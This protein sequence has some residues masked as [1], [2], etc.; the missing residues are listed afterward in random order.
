[1]KIRRAVSV[2]LLAG[3]A[4]LAA[5]AVNN[6]FILRNGDNKPFPVPA[7]SVMRVIDGDTFET[8]EKQ[9]IRLASVNSP[10]LEYCG[11]PEAKRALE[12]KLLNHPVYLK[13]LY[14]DPYYRLIS[15]VYTDDGYINEEMVREGYGSYHLTGKSAQNSLLAVAQEARTAKRGIHGKPCTQTEN[16]STPSCNIKANVNQDKIYYIPDCFQYK[17][18]VV[19]LYKG[20][21]WFCTEAEAQ[22]AG[23][24]KAKQCN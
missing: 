15:L 19:E 1:M 8:T 12:K 2:G 23:F 21:K 11:G 4:I 7:Y 22:K 6:T 10:E 16:I 24:R 18:T 5:A 13:V 17:N 20:D 3:S 14:R 9:L